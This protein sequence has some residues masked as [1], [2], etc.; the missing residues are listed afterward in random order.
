MELMILDQFCR[1][2]YMM[3]TVSVR[4]L[5]YPRSS[6]LLL[7]IPALTSSAF[8]AT[9]TNISLPST[10]WHKQN[11]PIQLQYISKEAKQRY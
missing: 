5:N 10:I 1:Q 3:T 7:L 4:C 9:S 11:N 8:L 2:I 6:A